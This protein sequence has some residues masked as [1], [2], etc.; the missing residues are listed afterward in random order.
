MAISFKT[1]NGFTLI[2]LLVVISII[3]V[4]SSV[5][6]ASLNSARNKAKDAAIKQD[7]RQIATLMAL[8]YDDYGSYS[9]LQAFTWLN[10]AGEC[11]SVFAGAYAPQLRAICVHMNS[12]IAGAAGVNGT[13]WAVWPYY[14]SGILDPNNS[15]VNFSVMAYLPGVGQ[16]AC[17]GSSGATSYATPGTYAY[18]FGPG[19]HQNP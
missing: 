13:Y 15:V 11:N 3:G 14:P 5:V 7:L 16:Y 1:E 8:N 9:N 6:L 18:W 12:L 4:L 19:C 17:V 2:E 10:T